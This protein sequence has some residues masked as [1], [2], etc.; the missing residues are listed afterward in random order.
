MR[1]LKQYRNNRVE[2]ASPKRLLVMLF[3]AAV[4][5]QESAIL[6]IEA[7]DMP[8]ARVDLNK[9]RAIFIEL[10]AGLDPDVDSDLVARL[11]RL[12]TWCIQQLI[13]AEREREVEPIRETIRLTHELLAAWREAV[14]SPECPE[15]EAP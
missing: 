2:S 4:V 8:T 5:R 13:Q 7:D 1:G 12:Y 3:E 14:E 10:R 6:A 9:A 11:S 15:L